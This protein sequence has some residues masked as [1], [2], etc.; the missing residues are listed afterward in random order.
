[1]R[2][3]FI[4]LVFFELSLSRIEMRLR[5]QRSSPDTDV[6]HIYFKN[7]NNK[8]FIT[9]SIHGTPYVFNLDLFNKTKNMVG[10]GAGAG[11]EAACGSVTL[12][13]R[14]NTVLAEMHQ[15]TTNF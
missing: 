11:A 4:L 3:I 8:W 6:Q 7:N 15:C 14:N 1:M 5:L 13:S 9:R 2:K 10:A 12:I